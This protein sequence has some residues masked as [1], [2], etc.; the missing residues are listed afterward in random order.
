MNPKKTPKDG[1]SPFTADLNFIKNLVCLPQ[2]VVDAFDPVLGA[3]LL[4]GRTLYD[5]I[6][7]KIFSGNYF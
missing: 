2:A 1:Q 5:I 7:K 3:N 6:E 4:F